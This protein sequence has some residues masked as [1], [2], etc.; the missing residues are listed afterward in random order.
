[1]KRE[2]KPRWTLADINNLID[3]FSNGCSLKDM[4]AELGRGETAV[5]ERICRLR[6]DG[7]IPA[8]APVHTETMPVPWPFAGWD[9]GHRKHPTFLHRQLP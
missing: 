3:M 9:E 5:K 4:A 6:R 7:I 8:A 2:S 1:M